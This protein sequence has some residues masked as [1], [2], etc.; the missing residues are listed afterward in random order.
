[1]A[2][3]RCPGDALCGCSAARLDHRRRRLVQP[4][5][6]H[7]RRHPRTTVSGAWAT[8]NPMERCRITLLWQNAMSPL[9]EIGCG[10]AS[11]SQASPRQSM[12]QD[13]AAIM[14]QA[15]ALIRDQS[16]S[17]VFIHLPVPHP[18]GHVRSQNKGGERPAAATSITWRLP[19]ES[20]GELLATLAQPQRPQRQP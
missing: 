4:L 11:M 17:F 5:L 7:S 19:T 13:L 8:A 14:P 6:P 16:I 1:M 9:V 18:P 20:L 2:S 15:E 3:L 10:I 12:A